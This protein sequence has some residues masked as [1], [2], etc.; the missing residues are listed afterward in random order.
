MDTKTG[1]VISFLKEI[2]VDVILM[3]ILIVCAMLFP[4]ESGK[5]SVITRILVK[6]IYLGSIYIFLIGITGKYK[7]LK[8]ILRR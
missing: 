5:F 3:V 4:I 6:G 7:I 2:Y 8:R 1:I